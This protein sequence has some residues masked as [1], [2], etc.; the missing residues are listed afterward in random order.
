MSRQRQRRSQSDVPRLFPDTS[1]L[2]MILS[3]P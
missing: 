2:L 3:A 1:D